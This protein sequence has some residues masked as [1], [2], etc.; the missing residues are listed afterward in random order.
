M[1]EL[2]ETYITFGECL[3]SVTSDYLMF[4]SPIEKSEV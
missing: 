1:K 4:T 3:L 2:K